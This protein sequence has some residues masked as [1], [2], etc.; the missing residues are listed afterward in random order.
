MGI[1]DNFE[2]GRVPPAEIVR[3]VVDRVPPDV[4]MEGLFLSCTNFQSLE[5]LP[6]LR[7]RYGPRVLSSVGVLVDRTLEELGRLRASGGVE[8]G[9]RG[10]L[11]EG[12]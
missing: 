7:S 1:R 9:S 11:R 2:L 5:A 4:G 8:A 12:G 3:F 10:E 6:S